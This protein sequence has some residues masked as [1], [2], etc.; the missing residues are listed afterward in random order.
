MSLVHLPL[1]LD[2][3]VARTV[4]ESADSSVSTFSKRSHDDDPTKTVIGN[5]VLVRSTGARS[6]QDAVTLLPRSPEHPNRMT[7]PKVENTAERQTPRRTLVM[8]PLTVLP[9][10]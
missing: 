7:R 10:G 5:E 1:L 3:T 2:F 4:T 9:F 8:T 6:D